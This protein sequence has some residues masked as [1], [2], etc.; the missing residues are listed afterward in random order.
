MFATFV[1][2][3]MQSL[4]EHLAR[5]IRLSFAMGYVE[6]A[7]ANTNHYIG[8]SFVSG[9]Q[10]RILATELEVLARQH[11]SHFGND[12]SDKPVYTPLL[13]FH[14]TPLYIVLRELEGAGN[15]SVEQESAFPWNKVQF[16]HHDQI[17]QLAMESKQFGCVPIILTYQVAKSFMFRDMDNALKYA[18][19]FLKHFVSYVLFCCN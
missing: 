17:I 10:I 4:L 14:L 7:A 6:F 2:E 18:D 19:A 16:S 8:R 3:P 12:S 5:A 1:K 13:Q 15:S 9:K 11:G